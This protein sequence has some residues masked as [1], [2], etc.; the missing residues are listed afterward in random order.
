MKEKPVKTA[1]GAWQSQEDAN[2]LIEHLRTSR[3]FSRNTES[4]K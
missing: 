4:F 2:E 3:N 1:F